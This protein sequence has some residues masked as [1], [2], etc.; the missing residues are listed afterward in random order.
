MKLLA[1]V[2]VFC[3]SLAAPAQAQAQ[4]FMGYPCTQD[5]SGHQAGYDWAE[6]KGIADPDICS[7]HSNSFVEGCRAYAEEQQDAAEIYDVP[8]EEIPD[9]HHRR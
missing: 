2:S 6:D 1:V 7:G 9:N 5:C 3:L 8:E 4:D